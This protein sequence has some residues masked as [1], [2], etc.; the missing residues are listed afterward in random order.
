MTARATPRTALVAG[1]ALL[2]CASAAPHGLLR[3][4]LS[5]A[6]AGPSSSQELQLVEAVRGAAGGEGL[7]CRPGVGGELLRCSPAAVGNAGH[8]LVVV[9]RRAGTGYAVSVDQH[10]RLPGMSSPVCEAQAR[11][12]GRLAAELGPPAVRVDAGS[13]CKR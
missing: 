1:A 12:Q 7:A 9:L 6:D 4:E 13:G 5:G 3:V 8:A 10:V 11:I 2:A